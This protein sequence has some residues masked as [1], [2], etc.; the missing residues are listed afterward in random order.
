MDDE[1]DEHGQGRPDRP[2]IAEIRAALG[3]RDSRGDQDFEAIFEILERMDVESWSPEFAERNQV[4]AMLQV[5]AEELAVTAEAVTVLRDR[6]EEAKRARSKIV[7]VAAEMVRE[8]GRT[9]TAMLIAFG[10]RPAR[11]RNRK[12][13]GDDADGLE[14]VGDDG[15]DVSGGEAWSAGGAKAKNRRGAAAAPPVVEQSETP[16]PEVPAATPRRQAGSLRLPTSVPRARG[17]RPPR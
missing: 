4:N 16:A 1:Q 12:L 2:T 5:M 14:T 15:D 7:S 8:W 17:K 9:G 3:A 13:G 6:L 10:L 11:V